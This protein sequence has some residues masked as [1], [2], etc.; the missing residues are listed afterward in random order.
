MR[1]GVE[2]AGSP[3]PARFRVVGA[4]DATVVLAGRLGPAV[5]LESVVRV[6]ALDRGALAAL[7]APTAALVVDVAF[8]EALT[9]A[10]RAPARLA[11]GADP[12][13]FAAWRDAAGTL[14]GAAFGAL[15]LG[16]FEPVDFLVAMQ[17]KAPHERPDPP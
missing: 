7:A 14:A 11:G 17:R 15:G 16:S 10:D 5:G 6:L 12:V 8:V 3:V 13:P 9:D 2:A 1:S 4:F